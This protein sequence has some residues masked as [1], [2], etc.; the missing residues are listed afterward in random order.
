[1]SIGRAR[2]GVLLGAALLVLTAC[3]GGTSSDGPAA[4][5]SRT[6]SPTPTAEGNGPA[7][8][9]LDLD[10]DFLDFVLTPGPTARAALRSDRVFGA[11]VGW[12]QCPD[13][14]GIPE[15]RASGQPMPTKAAEFV[16]IGLTNGPSFTT[17]PCLAS[18]V[19]YV[20]DRNLLGAAYAVHSFPDARTLRRY[21]GSGPFDSGTR[22]GKL[23][24]AGHAAAR[25]NQA[26]MR[27]A[28]M[29]SPVIW[30]DV[31]PV[32]LFPWSGSKGANSAVVQG[33]IRGY[34]D[35]GFRIGF[36]STKFLWRKIVGDLRTGAPEWRAAGQTSMAEA[37]RRCGTSSSFQGG[38]GV[39]G[40]WVE[41]GRDRNVTC[42]GAT[43]SLA[44]WFHQY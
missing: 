27:R 32:G 16:I 22:A 9:E 8:P 12:P 5:A 28:G 41:A 6:A 2:P 31:E 44:E 30:I 37:L 11:D 34:Q 19:R 13:G 24:N 10:L 25:F 35:A 29:R 1:M 21:G 7:V 15:R 39:L 18:Q 38:R 14:M 33:A 17:N 23:R 42:P 43:T 40:Q 36:Y 26:T 3:G 4:A 20:D